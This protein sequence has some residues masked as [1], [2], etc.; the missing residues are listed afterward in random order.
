MDGGLHPFIAF[1][2]FSAHP[3]NDTHSHTMTSSLFLSVFLKLRLFSSSHF[4]STRHTTGFILSHLAP[5]PP[6]S[7]VLLHLFF[8]SHFHCISRFS[9]SLPPHLL[10]VSI[11]NTVTPSLCFLYILKRTEYDRGAI[12]SK[13]WV[14][15]QYT[16]LLQEEA[17]WV[18]FCS[19]PR[20]SVCLCVGLPIIMIVW[21]DCF[22]MLAVVSV[23]K[24]SPNMK[25]LDYE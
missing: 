17:T 18:F 6:P 8:A 3:L 12:V 4:P 20:E 22:G 21:E 5:F 13:G 25:G 19:L 23:C 15:L 7:Y 11:S 1:T 2:Y 10:S 24:C 9:L 16:R 14:G